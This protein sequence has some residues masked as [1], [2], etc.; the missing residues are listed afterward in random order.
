VVS[1]QTTLT[2]SICGIVATTVGCDRSRVTDD[3]PVL[4]ES[5][6]STDLDLFPHFL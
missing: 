1:I 5:Q 4:G 6:G 2:C 3:A